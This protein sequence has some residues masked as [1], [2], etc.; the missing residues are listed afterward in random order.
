GPVSEFFD[1]SGRLRSRVLAHASEGLRVV[2]NI[3][4]RSGTEQR[5]GINQLA[6]GCSDLLDR[7][8]DLRA[9]GAPL[10]DVPGAYYDDLE[11]RLNP[12]RPLLN[13]LRHLGV[14]YDQ[15]GEGEFFH[16]YTPL[17]GGQYYVELLERRGGYGGFGAPNTPVRLAMQARHSA[18]AVMTSSAARSARRR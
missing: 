10:L 1:P 11:A 3:V 13:R 15:D 2:L 7:V 14:L 5:T 4:V 18:T 12:E 8:E 17:I 9:A 6:F 16:V